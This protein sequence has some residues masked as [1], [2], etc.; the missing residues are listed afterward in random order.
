MDA[1]VSTLS[2]LAVFVN[3]TDHGAVRSVHGYRVVA[4]GGDCGWEK[5]VE[6]EFA[7]SPSSC[8]ELPAPVVAPRL[9][10]A[11]WVGRPVYHE[12][13][14]VGAWRCI[15]AFDSVAAV[16]PPPTP[17]PMLSPSG[18]PGLMSVPSLYEDLNEVFQFQNSEKVPELQC[19][20]D[21]QSTRLDERERTSNEIGESDSDSDDDPQTGEGL[22]EPVQKQRRANQKYI[23]SITLVDI[24]QYF[25]LPIRE[26]S[27]TLKIGV[28]ILKR[29]CRQYGIPR[30][31]HR[32]IKSLDSLIHDLEYV[33]DD[34]ERDGVQ[35]EKA[36][37]KKKEREMEKEKE[38]HDA[39][40]AL[41]K[42]KKMLESEKETITLKPALDL[43]AETKQFR[44]D[45][46]KRRYRAKNI[47]TR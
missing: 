11:D 26:A 22:P 30:W 33:I 12:G 37:H 5:W 10:S 7:F 1:V 40:R 15:L 29:K 24:A 9:L 42:R 39:I 3:T 46:F 14:M 8:R 2:A 17:P 19:D 31:P 38:K 27:K 44:E 41:A 43:M 45:V 18:N 23:A 35:R 32:K 28:S 16:V 4:K 47:A 25:H 34:T 21:E 20:P 13:K 6:R 36:K